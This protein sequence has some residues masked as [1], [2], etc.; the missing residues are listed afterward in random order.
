[1]LYFVEN[2]PSCFHFLFLVLPN[3]DKEYF[4]VIQATFHNIS[5]SKVLCYFNE[6]IVLLIMLQTKPTGFKK[7][8]RNN[9]SNNPKNFHIVWKV[10][11]LFPSDLK[12]CQTVHQISRL[13]DRENLDTKKASRFSGIF[14][15]G[16]QVVLILLKNCWLV[17]NSLA[18]FQTIRSF[19]KGRK[20]LGL[21]GNLK[22]NPK[23]FQI[24]SKLSR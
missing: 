22:P 11:G 4:F 19:P 20:A 5:F 3:L 10:C 16:L 6:Q 21:A 18:S 12:T 23:N 14:L 13:T 1:M 2:N 24:N 15:V 7:G 8:K 9:Y 17:Q